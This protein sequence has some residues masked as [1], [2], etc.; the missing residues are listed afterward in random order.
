MMGSMTI[1]RYQTLGYPENDNTLIGDSYPEFV[2]PTYH[3]LVPMMIPKVFTRRRARPSKTK[4]TIMV[5]FTAL[6]LPTGSQ[7]QHGDGL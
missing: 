2:L 6:L 5:F 4:A 1:S 3:D 7:E